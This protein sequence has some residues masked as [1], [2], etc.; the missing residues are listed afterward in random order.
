MITRAIIESINS[1]GALVR[2]PKI[3]KS[4]VAVGSNN[5]S[6]LDYAQI[7]TLPGISPRYQPGDA[8]FIGFEDD[9]IGNPV[10]IGKL[11]NSNSSSVSDIDIHN[12]KVSIDANL[13][14][15]LSIGKVKSNELSNLS[16]L[17]SNI[18]REFVHLKSELNEKTQLIKSLEAS[19]KE[20]TK[21]IDSLNIE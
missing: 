11:N 4:N 7:C 9:D 19:I 8:V 15:S 6:E 12:L 21:R 14:E 20:L 5:T 3:N 1:K 13:P 18:Q 16:G 2:I 17:E 10:V